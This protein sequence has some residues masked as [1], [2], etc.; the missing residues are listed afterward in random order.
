MGTPRA[1]A[2]AILVS[3][4]PSE[5]ADG[6]LDLLDDAKIREEAG[7]VIGSLARGAGPTRAKRLLDLCAGVLKEELR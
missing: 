1:E 6:L 4:A 2:L 3:L 5:G 7:V